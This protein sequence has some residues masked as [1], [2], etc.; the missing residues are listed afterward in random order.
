VCVCIYIYIYIAKSVSCFG[1]VKMLEQ[2]MQ[3]CFPFLVTMQ[4]PCSAIFI[5]KTFLSF[6]YKV[7]T[8]SARQGGRWAGALL[9]LR[10]TT[11]PPLF[12]NWDLCFIP[13]IHLHILI[14]SFSHSLFSLI[15]LFLILFTLLYFFYNILGIFILFKRESY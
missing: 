10:G 9:F 12:I 7:H 14:S 1:V 2:M 5:S 4:S 15:F 13:K 6:F 8:S 3:L 11:I